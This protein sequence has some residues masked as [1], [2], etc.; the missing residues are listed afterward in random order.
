MESDLQS[1]RRVSIQNR[2]EACPV[3]PGDLEHWR[4]IGECAL[5]L[6]EEQRLARAPRPSCLGIVLVDDKAIAVLHGDFLDDPTPTDVMTFPLGDL[7]EIVVSVE[8]AR[9]QAAEFGQETVREIALYVVHGILHLCGYDDNTWRG[10]CEMNSLQE[11]LLSEA[12]SLVN[13][14][15]TSQDSVD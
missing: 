7:G 5:A 14:S 9:R 6:I 11:R 3:A 15:G 8:T 1:R 10:Q 12:E 13:G 4:A 2:Q